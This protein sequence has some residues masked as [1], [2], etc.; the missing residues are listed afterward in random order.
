MI[1]YQLN[2]FLKYFLMT[3]LSYKTIKLIHR[4]KKEKRKK[5]ILAFLKNYILVLNPFYLFFTSVIFFDIVIY[6]Y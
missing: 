1:P 2:R 6:S 3:R 4:L 5:E